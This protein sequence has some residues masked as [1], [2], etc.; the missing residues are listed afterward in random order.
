MSSRAPLPAG[1]A[2]NRLSSPA[3]S[4]EAC[5]LAAVA[6]YIALVALLPL[7]R[8]FWTALSP[9]ESGAA[10]G[11]LVRQWRSPSAARALRHTLE[12]GAWSVLVS[13]AIGTGAALLIVLSDVRAKTL[14]TFA[15]MLPM[16][17]PA[18]ITALAWVDMLAP[19]GP[20]QVFARLAGGTLAGSNPLYSGHG[21]AL[22]MGVEHAPLV[23]LAVRAGLARLPRDMIESAR[24]AGASPA[25][26]LRS[27]ILPA[28]APALLGGGTMAFIA[29]IANFGTPAI[30]GIPGRYP[31]LTTLIYQRLQGF[32]P[33]ALG[34]VA[35]LA[36]ILALLAVAGLALRALL[37]RRAHAR[38]DAAG[39]PFAG[40]ELGAW[41]GAASIALWLVLALIAVLPLL[42]LVGVSLSPAIGVPLS[43]RTA[44][45]DAYRQVLGSETVRRAFLN[46]AMLAG[47]AALGCVAVSVPLAYLAAVRRLRAA[48]VLDLVADLSYAV[49]GT[50]LALGVILILLR[51]LPL[52]GVSLYGTL[53]ILGFAYLA[54]FLALALR[55]VMAGAEQ[56]DRALDEAG[57]A[58]GAGL[59]RR[60]AFIVLPAVAPSAVA[61]AL[62][63]FM[64]AFNELTVSALLWSTGN[65]TVG[66][67]VFLYQYEGDAAAATALASL[68]LAF[69]LGLALMALLLR[70]YLPEGVLRWR[71]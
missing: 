60:L 52:V 50:V 32:G 5:L 42:A 25:R 48:R 18:Q 36:L 70:R 58:A 19:S 6:V 66:V 28:L 49:P 11:A 24:L 54:R 15:V 45:L 61:A 9:D 22:V 34:Q 27:V 14:A 23:F 57:Q 33:G 40:F 12:T 68:S 64:A 38:L 17:I 1:P 10:F 41:R 47:G 20:L 71:V 31:M 30:L 35:S 2:P 8:L 21:I 7:A 62:L 67:A 26:V 37:A 65:E 4:A 16:L 43:L 59:W 51:P 29:S 13:M 55:P 56:F 3:F 63:V 39:A 44:T 69:T 53:G 46:S